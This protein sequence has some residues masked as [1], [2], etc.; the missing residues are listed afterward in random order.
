MGNTVGGEAWNN[1]LWTMA[2][3]LLVI[4]IA[5]VLLVRLLNARRAA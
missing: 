2:L 1:A 3:I 4:S 5:F